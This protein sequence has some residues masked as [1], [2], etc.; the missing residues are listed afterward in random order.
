MLYHAFVGEA[1]SRPSTS[2]D[3]SEA[4]GKI[5]LGIG[6]LFSYKKKNKGNI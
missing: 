6:K 5:N 1:I 2:I 4:N 3:F